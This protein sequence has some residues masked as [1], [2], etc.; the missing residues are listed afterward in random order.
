[1]PDLSVNV[2]IVPPVPL[3]PDASFPLSVTTWEKT[4][5]K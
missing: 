4:R 3:D 2:I 5:S 1:M